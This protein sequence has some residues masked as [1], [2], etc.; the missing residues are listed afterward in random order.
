MPSTSPRARAGVR[1]LPRPA[2][3]RRASAAPVPVARPVEAPFAAVF[4]VLVAAEY[5]YLG[6]LLYA[7]GSFWDWYVVV[8]AVLAALSVAGAALVVLGR[9]RGWLVLSV[10]AG[11]L[12]IGLLALVLLFGALGGGAALWQALLLLIGPLGCL[13]LALRRPVREWSGKAAARRST[14]G[15]RS[16]GRAS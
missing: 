16:A 4:G 7:P 6:W 8:P 5:L 1:R 11:V 12:L 13:A 10:V 2:P 9:G 14:G 3:L 15:Q